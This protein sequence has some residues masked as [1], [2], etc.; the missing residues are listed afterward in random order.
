MRSE[1]KAWNAAEVLKTAL[2]GQGMGGGHHDMAGG[3]I[4]A[5]SAFREEAFR[6]KI[7]AILGNGARS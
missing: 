4:R 6:K 5:P 2:A 7:A 3:V 1:N